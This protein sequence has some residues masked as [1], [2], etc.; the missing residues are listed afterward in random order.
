MAILSES[1]AATYF[2]D[3]TLTGDALTAAIAFAQSI[4]EGPQGANR[5]LEKAEFIEI[6]RLSQNFQTIRLSYNPIATSPAIALQ[7]R[8]GNTRDRYG[9]IQQADVWKDI[10]ASCYIVDYELAQITIN[11]PLAGYT[12]ARVVYTG[13]YDFSVDDADTRAMKAALG[14]LLSL[15]QT[16]AAT[17]GIESLRVENQAVTYGSSGGKSGGGLYADSMAMSLEVFKKYRA[18]GYQFG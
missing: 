17:S 9:Y 3:V 11:R 2:P 18:G 1:D 10:E 12:M 16:Q 13:G 8:V 5:P 7:A 15:Q 4:A 14:R 6:K